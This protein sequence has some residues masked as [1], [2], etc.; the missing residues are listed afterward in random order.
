MP[1]TYHPKT[2]TILLCN[3]GSGFRPPEMVK[4]RPAV[5]ISPQT[6]S[7]ARL[8]TIVPLSATPPR[9]VLAYHHRLVISPPLP[10]PWNEKEVW[11]KC[12]MVFATGYDRLDLIRSPRIPGQPRE[13]RLDV[14][15][16]SDL[17]GIRAGILCSLGLQ[18]L[19]NHL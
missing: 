1:L 15:P 4:R 5:V 18:R 16:E 7:R 11:V 3:F 2:G 12:D 19:T 14:L 10:P 9:P 6:S 17:R 8:C 13:Y